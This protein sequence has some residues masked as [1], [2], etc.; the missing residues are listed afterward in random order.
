MEYDFDK[1][2]YVHEIAIN[3]ITLHEKRGKGNRLNVYNLHYLTSKLA[4]PESFVNY[5]ELRLLLL[6]L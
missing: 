4:F 1:I 2:I 6:L 5:S 3:L